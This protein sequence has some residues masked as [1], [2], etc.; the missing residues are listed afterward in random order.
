MYV[1]L[2]LVDKLV[3]VCADIER[4]Q[5]RHCLSTVPRQV[6]F[7]AIQLFQDR[8]SFIAIQ[9]FTEIDLGL[10][11]EITRISKNINIIKDSFIESNSKYNIG[12]LGANPYF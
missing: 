12:L 4:T 9:L 7:I 2:G 3:R 5:A 1:Y 10:Y 8:S 6:V 11:L